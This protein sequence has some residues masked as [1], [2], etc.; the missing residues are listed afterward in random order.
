[1]SLGVL[2]VLHL[3]LDGPDGGA[4]GGLGDGLTVD[5]GDG[6]EG[7]QFRIVFGG[8]PPSEFLLEGARLPGINRN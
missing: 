7:K 2:D 1:M 4:V 6:I 3:L 5:G 8:R